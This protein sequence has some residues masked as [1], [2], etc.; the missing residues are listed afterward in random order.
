MSA[1]G[2]GFDEMDS[3]EFWF[4]GSDK[5]VEGPALP[6]P[7]YAHFGFSASDGL[8][9][10]TGNVKIYENRRIFYKMLI[11]GGGYTV[12]DGPLKDLYRFQCTIGECG[13]NKMDQ[14]LSFGRSD[15]VAF[16]IPDS[17]AT[18]SNA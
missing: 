13:W 1:G 9:F 2:F 6:L 11:L 4:V 15:V 17:L 7:L 14:Q 8:S 3:T 12:S 10:I 5:F 16:L 18:C